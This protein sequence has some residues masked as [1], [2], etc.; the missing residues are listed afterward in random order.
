M[1]AA[2]ITDKLGLHSLRQRAWVS[3]LINIRLY[4]HAKRCPVHSIDLRNIWRRSLRRV[5]MVEQLAPE[6][7]TQLVGSS[8]PSNH[9]PIQS[10]STFW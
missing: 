1:N 6:G 5:G 7:W 9:Q 4:M 2:E 10:P 3:P 8:K